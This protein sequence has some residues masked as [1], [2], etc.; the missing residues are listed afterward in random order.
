MKLL[1]YPRTTSLFIKSYLEG[2]TLRQCATCAGISYGSSA[3]E[4]GVSVRDL[5][6]DHFRRN[7]VQETL[8]GDIEIDES[9]FGRRVKYHRGNPNVGMKV[10]IFGMVERSS[11]TI[12]L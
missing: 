3:V 10:W 11:N 2:N 8:S 9:L 7:V 6:K 4:C 12:I 5:F 1:K